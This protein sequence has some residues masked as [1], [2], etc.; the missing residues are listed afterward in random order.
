MS[1]VSSIPSK[2][3]ISKYLP[4]FEDYPHR[5]KNGLQV[6]FGTLQKV[7]RRR[8]LSRSVLHLAHRVTVPK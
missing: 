3:F 7:F 5:P 4:E 2:S 1:L 8:D 6:Q